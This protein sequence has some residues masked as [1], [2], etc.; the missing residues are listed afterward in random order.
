LKAVQPLA[1]RQFDLLIRAARK[2]AREAGMRRP[3]V[4]RA[5]RKARRAR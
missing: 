5:V 1:M 4:A 2:A 3:A